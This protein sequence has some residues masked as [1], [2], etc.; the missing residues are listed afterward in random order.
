MITRALPPWFFVIAVILVLQTVS[1][2]LGRL[3]PIAGPAFTAEFGSGNPVIGILGEFDALP[4]LSQ[5]AVPFRKPRAGGNAEELA[6][7]DFD[8][9]RAVQRAPIAWR[10]V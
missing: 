1:A 4:E 2:T 3:V 6:T 5:E 9:G 10:G 8:V 7:K